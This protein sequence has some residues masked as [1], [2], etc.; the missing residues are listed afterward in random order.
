MKCI[1]CNEIEMTDEHV[2]CEE[3]ND[4]VINLNID[5]EE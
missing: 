1:L 3:C 2:A 4:F 5:D